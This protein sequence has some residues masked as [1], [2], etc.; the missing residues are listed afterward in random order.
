MYN[1]AVADFL[2]CEYRK[3]V[4]VKMCRKEN[5]PLL[6][7]LFINKPLSSFYIILDCM[8]F[9]F[10]KILF[11][12]LLI[13][14]SINIYINGHFYLLSGQLMSIQSRIFIKEHKTADI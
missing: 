1:D 6:L 9:I 13:D 7:R 8:Q 12:L 14:L 3:R 5:A 2:L 10:G 11:Q 4:M